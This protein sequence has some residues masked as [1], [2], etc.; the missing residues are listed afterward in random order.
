MK[1][2][3]DTSVCI[4]LTAGNEA[5]QARLRTF[6]P[7]EIGLSAITLME[8][9]KGIALSRREYRKANRKDLEFLTQRFDVLPFDARAAE[10]AARLAVKWERAGIRPGMMDG[11]IAAHAAS[12]KL[13]LAYSD[14]DYNRFKL[15][16]LLFWAKR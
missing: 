12:L 13:Y 4:E 2:L 11:L 6:K 9:E 8:L 7:S 1:L 15:P 14:G 3:L 10:T 16:R 5:M